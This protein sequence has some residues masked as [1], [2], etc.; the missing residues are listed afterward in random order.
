MTLQDELLS[1]A[2]ARREAGQLPY[3]GA[4]SPEEAYRL[5][6]ADPSAR[7]VD[8][9][10][11]AELDWVGGPALPAEQLVHVEWSG[12]PG[13]AQNPAFVEQLA[14]QVAQD[15]PLLFLCRSAA[16]SKHAARTATQAGFKIAIDVLEGFEGKPDAEGHRN[17][18]EG[19]RFR[20]LPWRGA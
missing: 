10:T 6:Q 8:V 2:G 11:K 19:W 16:R 15:A 9:R 3:Y 18:V 12:Y 14:A 7:L 17:T 20:K 5:L 1:A 13:G 4:L